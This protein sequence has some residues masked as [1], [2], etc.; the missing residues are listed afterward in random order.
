MNRAQGTPKPVIKEPHIWARTVW[1]RF[2]RR[3][4]A[5]G[6]PLWMWIRQEFHVD[7]ADLGRAQALCQWGETG[8]CILTNTTNGGYTAVFSTLNRL[9]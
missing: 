5:A 2:H 9:L 7:R 4:A 6:T 3:E 1:Q 8:E